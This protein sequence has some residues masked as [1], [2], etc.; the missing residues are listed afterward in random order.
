MARTFSNA[1]ASHDRNAST[2]ALAAR[3]VDRD[4]DVRN[5]SGSIELTFET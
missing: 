4:S 1:D 3:V 5:L 2:A